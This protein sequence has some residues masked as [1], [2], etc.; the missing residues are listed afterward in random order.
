MP[1]LPKGHVAVSRDKACFQ[2]QVRRFRQAVMASILLLDFSPHIIALLLA[3]PIVPVNELFFSGSS[4]LR[5][6]R[7]LEIIPGLPKK[8]VAVG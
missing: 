3:I 1:G 5:K 8:H 7:I 2:Y 4:Y 6:R